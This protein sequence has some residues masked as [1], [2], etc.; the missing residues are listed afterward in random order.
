MM[1]MHVAEPLCEQ[2]QVSVEYEQNLAA[3]DLEG[4]FHAR[5]PN[6]LR[7]LEDACGSSSY[8]HGWES[9]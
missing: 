6:P 9:R 4:T 7:G 1:A 3:C 2:A 5:Y 8:T